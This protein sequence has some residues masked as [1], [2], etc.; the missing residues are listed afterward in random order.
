M[1]STKKLSFKEKKRKKRATKID[2][3]K[4]ER[5]L[6]VQINTLETNDRNNN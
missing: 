5:K 3:S 6:M 4:A 2:L 1:Y